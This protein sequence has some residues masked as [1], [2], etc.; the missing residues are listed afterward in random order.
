MLLSYYVMAYV[1]AELSTHLTVRALRRSFPWLI[2][3]ADESPEIDPEVVEQH[4]ARSFDPNLGWRRRAGETGTDAFEGGMTCYH[5]DQRRRRLNPGFGDRPMEIACF[6]DSFVFGRLVDDDQTWAHFLSRMLDTNVGNYGVGNYGIDQAILRYEEEIRDV[7][8]KVIVLGAVPETIARVLSYWKHFFE[9][10]NVLAFKPRF[11]LEPN[12]LVLHPPA[13]RVPGDYFVYHQLLD[14]IRGLDYFYYRKFRA[15]MLRFPYLP[16]LYLRRQ[17][18]LPI[19]WH[20]LSG[21]ILGN[22]DLKYR[23]AFNVV[24]RENAKWTEI[25]Y[26]EQEACV[27]LAKLIE[28]FTATCRAAGRQPL[29]VVIPQLMD[30]ER[31]DK[32]TTHEAF[33]DSLGDLLPVVD[34]SPRF[35]EETNWQRLYVPGKLGPHPSPEGNQLIADVLGPTVASLMGG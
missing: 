26:G 1:F 25:L 2:T 14:R 19:F 33:F 6:G 28:R 23:E 7:E 18:H 34:L 8:A 12:G 5:I 15:D 24:L 31:E 10:G 3:R 32:A 4:V 30:L 13:V 16:R 11:T 9:Y 27:L 20:L 35:R 22:R 21:A 29:L 17:R